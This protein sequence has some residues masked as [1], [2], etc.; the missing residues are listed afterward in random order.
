VIRKIAKPW[1]EVQLGFTFFTEGAALLS[2]TREREALKAQR[3][4]EAKAKS[5]NLAEA[6][7]LLQN[8]LLEAPLEEVSA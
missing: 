6:L 1:N 8:C 7:S 2:D 4:R 3:V 5:Y